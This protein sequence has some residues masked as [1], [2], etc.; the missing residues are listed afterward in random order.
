MAITSFK[1][2]SRLFRL[3]AAEYLRSLPPDEAELVEQIGA[4]LFRVSLNDG[5]MI[6]LQADVGEVLEIGV[7]LLKSTQGEVIRAWAAGVWL[8]WELLG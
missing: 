1:T 5:S 3:G 2:Q 4:G 6:E 8:G 7:L